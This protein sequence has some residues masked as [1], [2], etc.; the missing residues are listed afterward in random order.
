MNRLEDRS[1]KEAVAERHFRRRAGLPV[2]SRKAP[3]RRRARAPSKRAQP[4]RLSAALIELWRGSRSLFGS[5][6]VFSRSTRT[7][8]SYSLAYCKLFDTAA[9]LRN[10]CRRKSKLFQVYPQP[11]SF[12]L[13]SAKLYIFSSR[14][15]VRSALTDVSALNKTSLCRFATEPSVTLS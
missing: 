12:A 2:L 6:V 9:V 10:N 8:T 7:I 4:S 5:P 1:R 13:N 3:G 15:P 14:Q 11:G